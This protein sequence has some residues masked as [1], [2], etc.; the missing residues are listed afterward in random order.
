MK[1]PKLNMMKL[2]VIAFS[3]FFLLSILV[4]ITMIVG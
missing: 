2:A 4:T 1:I 3:V